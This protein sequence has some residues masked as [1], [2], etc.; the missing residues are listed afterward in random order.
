LNHAKIP[1]RR[2]HTKDAAPLWGYFLFLYVGDRC[3]IS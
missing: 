3:A 1:Q 2:Q